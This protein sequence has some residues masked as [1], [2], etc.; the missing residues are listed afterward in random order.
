MANR[1]EDNAKVLK[2]A[3]AAEIITNE[4]V[5]CQNLNETIEKLINDRMLLTQMGK[6]AEK[7]AA[8]NVE[9]KIYKEIKKVLKK[10]KPWFFKHYRL[11]YKNR[12]IARKNWLFYL[13]RR[14][15]KYVKK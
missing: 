7:L 10:W 2:N 13:K 8:L 3:G 15:L 1:Q 14:L 4:N 12:V 9:D 6:N 11:K 5:N